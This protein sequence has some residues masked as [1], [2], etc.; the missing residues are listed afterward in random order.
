MQQGFGNRH[1]GTKQGAQG[2]DRCIEG[3]RN[4]QQKAH[5]EDQTEQVKPLSRQTKEATETG[6]GR[7]GRHMPDRIQCVT[8]F[9]HHRR[10]SKQQGE[11]AEDGRGYTGTGLVRRLNQSLNRPGPFY[12][13]Q[14]LHLPNQTP[15]SRLLT[16][17][18]RRDGNNDNQERSQR[19][20]RIKCQRGPETGCVVVKP[21]RNGLFQECADL[22]APEV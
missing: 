9:H 4:Q 11:K 6:K 1:H 18:Q 22:G 13:D 17:C 8:Q 20:Q 2:G 21:G 10:R 5:S 7:R 16:E 19:Q 15:L 3:Q 12:S 14:I